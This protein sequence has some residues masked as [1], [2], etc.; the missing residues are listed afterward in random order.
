PTAPA[1]FAVFALLPF[2][3]SFAAWTVANALACLALVP[4]AQHTLATQELWVG[5]A[6][7]P[8]PWRLPPLALVALAA[9]L[10]ISDS[11]TTTLYLGQLG[12]LATVLLLAALAA[13]ARGRR[14]W[15]GIWLAL[16]TIKIATM[17]P[18]LLLFLRKADVRTWATLA[19]GVL[20]LCWATANLT[21]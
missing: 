21:E 15:A 9:V 18:F 8:A 19:V 14:V 1:V 5:G 2:E 10:F 20:G 6:P 16:A 7:R 17:L 12:V 11:S 4:F 13:Q 3:A